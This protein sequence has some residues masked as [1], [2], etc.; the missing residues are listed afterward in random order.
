MAWT[1]AGTEWRWIARFAE[2][3]RLCGLG[4]GDECV[5]LS[6][7]SSRADLVS[8]ALL[9]AESIGAKPF[10][11]VMRTPAN[12]QPVA[13]RSTGTALCL[14]GNGAAVAAISSVPFVIDI[15]AEGL[16]HSRELRDIL[17][18]GCE[19]FMISNEHPEA[20]ERLPHDEDMARRVGTSYDFMTKCRTMRAVSEF[21]TDLTIDLADAFLA[22][23]T[24]VTNGPG[25]IAHWPGGL[26]L[27]FPARHRVNGTVVLAPGDM[28]LTFKHYVQSPITLTVEDDYVVDIK[29]DGYQTDMLRSYMSAF[30]SD[31][32]AT[33]HVGWG[34]N[35]AAR[36][37]YLE[38]YDR[39]QHNGVEARAFEGNFMYS[40]G[41]NENAERFSVCHFD[42][43]MRNCDVYLDD[44]RVVHRGVLD[45]VA[46]KETNS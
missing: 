39:S 6:E 37:D 13:L 40:T 42:I 36:W 32:Y 4:P 38:L 17:A 22:G 7:S 12:D 5:I 15:T 3:F 11:V 20:F 24:G 45:G 14:R 21:G 28:N 35:P 19:V 46:A 9:A 16:L 10:Q 34:M 23:S 29:G 25:S 2:Q 41:A 30:D 1:N 18:A 26:V 27:A 33:S 43:P 44:H 31:A 8:T